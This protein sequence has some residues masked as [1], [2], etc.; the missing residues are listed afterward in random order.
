MGGLIDS[1]EQGLG[2]GFGSGN[3]EIHEQAELAGK[4]AR[5][6]DLKPHG[7]AA[8]ELNGM[9]GTGIERI[10]LQRAAHAEFMFRDGVAKGAGEGNRIGQ[11]AQKFR[12][13]DSHFSAGL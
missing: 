6:D 12:R 5:L 1:I 9:D 10:Q 11:G 8:S 4:L 7:H 2:E 3:I 13:H